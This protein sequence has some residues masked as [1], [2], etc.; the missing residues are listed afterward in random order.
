MIFNDALCSG[1]LSCGF[2]G[3]DFFDQFNK[4]CQFGNRAFDIRAL[5]LQQRNPAFAFIKRDPTLHVTTIV[6]IIKVNHFTDFR[7]A[8][9]D[10]LR[11]QY[12][13]KPRAIPFRIYT[14]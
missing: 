11:P 2:L 10:P 7:K 8:E 1:F 14:R 6:Q 9:T 13:S 5:R 4:A 3:L 12:P